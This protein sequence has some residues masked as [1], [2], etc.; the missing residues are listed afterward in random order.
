[1]T[2]SAA[3]GFAQIKYDPTGTSCKAIPYDFHPM[4]STSSPQTRVI[5]AAHTYNVA[6][7]DE[8]G[9]F[10]FCNGPN[11][12]PATPFGVDAQGNPIACPAGNTEGRGA[13]AS[14]TDGDDNFC[15]P[16]SEALLVHVNGCTDTNTGFDGVSYQP[17]WPD[18]NTALHPQPDPVHQPADRHA[19]TTSITA[20]G[21]R[22]GPAG[23]SSPTPATATTG[24]GCTLIPDDR[25][26][27]PGGLLPVLQHAPRPGSGHG[28]IWAFG[29]NLPGSNDF[30]RNAQY[31][32]LLSSSYL[33]F[34]GGGAAH[35]LI[36]NFRNIISNPC[37]A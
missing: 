18:G 11:P 20:D 22:G 3:N 6:F 37:R 25:H 5:W 33:I 30:G 4:Y 31:G 19:T 34:G 14:P 32:S 27:Q 35:N 15:F 9:H 24:A 23:E 1:M 8:I 29:N 7:S 2:A 12:I 36:N 28:C 21:V 17:V 10:E 16:G 13:N 26:G